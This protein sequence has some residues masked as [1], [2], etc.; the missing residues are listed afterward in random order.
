MGDFR[1]EINATGG[2]GCQRDIASG[3]LVEGCGEPG[4]PDCLARTFVKQL[5]AHGISVKDALFIHWPNGAGTVLDNLLTKERSGS[6][7]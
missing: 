5:R 6:F 4:C 2:H 3:G 7:R 1:F